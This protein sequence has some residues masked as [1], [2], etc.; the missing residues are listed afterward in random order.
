[1]N[2]ERK[3]L[4]TRD[5][6]FQRRG[7]W[8][9]DYYDAEGK[10][11]RKKAAPDYQTAKLIYRSTMSAIAKGEATGIREEGLTFSVFVE[12]RYWPALKPTVAVSWAER[13]RGILDRQLLPRF[14]GLAMTAIRREAIEAWYGERCAAV[15]ASTANKELGRLK[16]ALARASDWGYLRVSPAAR[17]R[18]AKEPTGRTRYLTDEERT[19]LLEG[20]EVTIKTSDGRAWTQRR[21]PSPVLRVYLVAALHTGA[22]R[23]EFCQLTGADVDWKAKTLTLRAQKTKTV[24]TL[25]MTEALEQLLRSLPRSLD[26]AAPLLPAIQPMELTRAFRRYVQA[27]GLA[28]LTFH[29]LRHDVGSTLAMAGVPQRAIMEI[30]GHRDLRMSARYQHVAP[31]HLRKAVGALG[32]AR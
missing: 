22:R 30:L 19:R 12:Q 3:R 16:H 21:A 8:W 6:L 13:T 29:D 17:I 32:Q 23:G 4:G 15:K 31:D 5:G 14:G 7:W 27:I 1:M 28:N 9:L 11:H 25:P 10:R 18:K 20:D 24:R 2:E 26:P